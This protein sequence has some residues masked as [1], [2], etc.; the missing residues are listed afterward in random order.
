MGRGARPLVIAHRG[1]SAYRPENTLAAFALAVEQRADMIETDLHLSRD[2]AIVVRH[3]ADLAGIG[4]RREIRETDLARIRE[5]DAGEGERVPTLDE[6]LDRFGAAIP[7]NL[8]L[9]VGAGGAYAGLEAAVLRAVEARGLLASTLFSSFDDRVLETLRG[10]SS[11]AR[12]AVLVSRESPDSALARARAV[13]AEAVNPWFGI[14]SPARIEAA[15]AAGLAVF[16]YTIDA[17]A[18]LRRFL[19]L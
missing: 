12:L 7:F 19:E 3:D 10:H 8:E 9:K 18:D 4:L 17:P 15:H 1:A 16:P 14:A 5:L 2:G 11:R 6:I 13:G